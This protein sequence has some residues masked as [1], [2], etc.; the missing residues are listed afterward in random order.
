M[1]KIINSIV[2]LDNNDGFAKKGNIPWASPKDLHFFKQQTTNNIVIMGLS[3]FKTL[4]KPLPNRFN[5]IVTSNNAWYAKDYIKENVDNVMFIDITYCKMILKGQIQ[6]SDF[7]PKKYDNDI[8]IIGGK[9]LLTDT[10]Q[11]CKYLFVTTIKKNYECDI[12]I[13]M[14]EILMNYGDGDGEIL[15]EDETLNIQK[16]VLKNMC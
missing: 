6:T 15:Y 4:S 13:N 16:Y 8:Y 14:R 12:F 3:T 11:Y 5:I 9:Q 1:T 7:V 2:A 10:L